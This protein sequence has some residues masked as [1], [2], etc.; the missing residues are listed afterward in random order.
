MYAQIVGELWLQRASART[1]HPLGIANPMASTLLSQEMAIW[2]L[3]RISWAVVIYYPTPVHWKSCW[4]QSYVISGEMCEARGH[5]TSF[6]AG[7]I[8]LN[9]SPCLSACEST[10]CEHVELLGCPCTLPPD[11]VQ[12]QM[13]PRRDPQHSHLTDCAAAHCFCLRR[14]RCGQRKAPKSA[15]RPLSTAPPSGS[16]ANPPSSRE[17][18]PSV[19][20]I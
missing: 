1:F 4:P 12:A 5:H 15:L 13:G 7:G 6:K 18:S 3:A 20:I 2:W 17:S 10:L 9:P 16:M 14:R 11:V 8:R 19:G